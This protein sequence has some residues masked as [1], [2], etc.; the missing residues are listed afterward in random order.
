MRWKGGHLLHLVRRRAG[1]RLLIG[2]NLG[3]INGWIEEQD[4]LG[5]VVE[6]HR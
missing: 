6:V 3:R 5:R 4:V 2:N 1:P